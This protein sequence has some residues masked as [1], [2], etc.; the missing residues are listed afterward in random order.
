MESDFD[1]EELL[2]VTRPRR[3]HYE[4]A[5]TALKLIAFS[6]PGVMRERLGCEDALGRLWRLWDVVGRKLSDDERLNASGLIL[7]RSAIGDSEF[8]TIQL[9]PALRVT[10]AHFVGIAF[11]NR[12]T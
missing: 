5:H 10:E 11:S 4:F 2:S 1:L 12:A 9:P 6:A 3:H 7:R 8:F